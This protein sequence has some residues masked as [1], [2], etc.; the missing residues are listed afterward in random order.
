MVVNPYTTTQTRPE[1]ETNEAGRESI[2]PASVLRPKPSKRFERGGLD[3]IPSVLTTPISM[4]CPWSARSPYAAAAPWASWLV[5][6]S[7]GTSVVS[8]AV[9]GV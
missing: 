8:G 1:Y 5:A 3:T 9:R 7:T 6:N 4:T 2:R